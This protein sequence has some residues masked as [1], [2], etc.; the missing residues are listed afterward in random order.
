MEL[1]EIIL[2]REDLYQEVWTE[3]MTT[4]ASKY[5]I[6]DVGLKKIC[7]K[8]DIPTP[9]LG[10]WAKKR[11]GKKVSK[12]PLPQQNQNTRLEYHHNVSPID[13]KEATMKDRVL[14]E[15]ESII[16]FEKQEKNKITI[17]ERLNRPHT[18]TQMLI[19]ESK[20]NRTCTYNLI[21]LNKNVSVGRNSL[22]RAIKVF[23]ALVK[24]L[25]ARDYLEIKKGNQLSTAYVKIFGEEYKFILREKIKRVENT[26]TKE[27]IKRPYLYNQWSYLHTGLLTLKIDGYSFGG[28]KHE[29]IDNKKMIEECLNEFI[30]ESAKIAL[31][32]KK[33]HEEYRRQREKQEEEDRLWEIAIEEKRKIEEARIQKELKQKAKIDLLLQQVKN[34]RQNQELQHFIT[35]IQ[36]I[37]LKSEHDVV[38]EQKFKVWLKWAKQITKNLNPIKNFNLDDYFDGE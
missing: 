6:S 16:E 33:E 31:F 12:K 21:E 20:F 38:E 36:E 9:S 25:E 23:D 19:S 22:Q 4:L 5:H 30:I 7:R 15:V 17:P 28:F 8:M 3:P 10:Y 29:W 14:K 24:A 34:F 27:E 2:K 13:V 11:A 35:A 18:L 37:F 1:R 32:K 26:P